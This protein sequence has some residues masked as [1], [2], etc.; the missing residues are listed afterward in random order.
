MTASYCHPKCDAECLGLLLK[1]LKAHRLTFRLLHLT[2]P[3]STLIPF[4]GISPSGIS[5]MVVDFNQDIQCEG[6]S[7]RTC[8]HS[9]SP[10]GNDAMKHAKNLHNYLQGF[11][12]SE[13][14][15]LSITMESWKRL[16]NCSQICCSS[17][18]SHS[19]HEASSKILGNHTLHMESHYVG[20]DHQLLGADSKKWIMI[21]SV[22]KDH[23]IFAITTKSAI[24]AGTCD[25]TTEGLPIPAFVPGKSI[26]P[27]SYHCSKVNWSSS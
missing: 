7:K 11:K 3:D 6:F 18:L 4:Q 1:Q 16:D 5:A 24:V 15:T 2:L 8:I 22:F 9:F 23:T 12:S 17:S 26:K 13:S 27:T 19:I 25:F 20:P 10:W 21:A 14:P